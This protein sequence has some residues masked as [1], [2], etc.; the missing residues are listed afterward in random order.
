MTPFPH[1]T[2]YTPSQFCL[3]KT[4]RKFENQG[5]IWLFIKFN[6]YPAFSLTH[7]A[8][9]KI[10]FKIPFIP[11]KLLQTDFQAAFEGKYILHLHKVL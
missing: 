10:L 6:R 9:C 3:T 2:P 8:Q 4:E 1:I 5:H 11:F 7:T